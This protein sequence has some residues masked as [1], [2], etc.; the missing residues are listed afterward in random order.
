[1]LL[2]RQNDLTDPWWNKYNYL[3]D[4][5]RIDAPAL[6][7]ESWNDFTASAALYA[8]TL[9]ER[10][11][12]SETTRRNQFIIISPASH[13]QSESMKPGQMIGDLD[14]G[15]PRFGHMDIYLQWFDR[16]LKGMDNG[17]TAM[18][19]IQYYLLGKNEW[20]SSDRWPLARTERVSYYFRS[21]G[22]ANTH[23]GDGVLATTTPSAESADRYRYDP[24]DPV[25][26]VGVNDYWGGK[27]IA[28]QREEVSARRDVLV[29]T[30]PP[31]AAGFEMTGDI[32]AVLYV[33]SSARD[34]DFVVKLVDVYPDGRAL[35]IR[36]NI[37]RARFRNGRD[38]PAEL[39]QPGKVYEVR[40]PLGAYSTWFA[41][42]HR[43][44][45]QITSS[46]FPRWDRNLNTGGNNYDETAW[47]IAENV[48]HHSGRYPS[49]IVLP[50]IR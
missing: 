33:S 31:L 2:T 9:F 35:N 18:P 11:G 24:G 26:S 47:V 30:S 1:L 29:Y 20:R 43:I 7:I 3:T 27:P 32:E 45:V 15:D 37:K 49:R 10:N 48:V 22:R 17:V 16:W 13:C 41:P 44:R 46:S 4:Q 12:V 28:D 40:I 23:D 38:R 39:M 34:T 25:P 14:A 42:G 6:F 50:V 36:E 19:K 8:R 21:G 5:D